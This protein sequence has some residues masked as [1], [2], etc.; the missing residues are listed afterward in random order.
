[1]SFP[2]LRNR[3]IGAKGLPLVAWVLALAL[4]AW[5]AAVSAPAVG[6]SLTRMDIG[7]DALLALALLAIFCAASIWFAHCVRQ[8]LLELGRAANGVVRGELQ[9]RVPLRRGPR[10][11]ADLTVDFNRMVEKL[12]Q[13]ETALLNSNSRLEERVAIR[14]AE[15]AAVNK[16]LEAFAYS[17]SHDLRAPLRLVDGFSHFLEEETG[18]TLSP[19]SRRH[20]DSIRHEVRR[21]HEMIEGLL[22]LSRLGRARLASGSVDLTALAREVVDGLHEETPDRVVNVTIQPDLKIHGDARLLHLVLQNLLGNAWKFTRHQASPHIDVG[23]EMK[24]GQRVYFVRDNGAG[25]DMAGAGRLFTPFQ[26]LHTTNEFEGLGIGLATVQR[27]IERHGGHVWADGKPGAGATVSFTLPE[28]QPS[29]GVR[30]P[31]EA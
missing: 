25:F 29:A 3:T 5:A 23:S 6:T 17:V 9:A 27:I 1:M 19:R 16:E 26:R 28:V 4:L 31:G 30:E 13:T 8:P 11:L 12:Q 7:M 10:E 22:V 14:T 24:D 18:S 21:M 20:L 2:E 15:L